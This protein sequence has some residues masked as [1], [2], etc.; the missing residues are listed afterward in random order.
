[1]IRSRYDIAIY[2]N[3]QKRI[4]AE[5]LVVANDGMGAT[6]WT[7]QY[8]VEGFNDSSRKGSRPAKIHDRVTIG[9]PGS[10]EVQFK[11]SDGRSDSTHLWVGSGGFPDHTELT[12]YIDP[13]G[14]LDVRHAIM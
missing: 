5:V 3:G 12:A 4:D 8:R 9:R 14:E 1:M 13:W 7:K 2:N 6:E 11:L 10:Y